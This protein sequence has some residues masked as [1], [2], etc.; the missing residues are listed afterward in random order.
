VTV[1]VHAIENAVEAMP[2]SGG[3]IR[4]RTARE[5]DHALISV[6]D[7]G[8][9]VSELGD[10]FEPL[11]STKGK[12][13]MGLGLSMIRSVA[14]AHGGSTSLVTREEGGAILEIKFPLTSGKAGSLE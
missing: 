10:V 1:L 8:P 11:V 9:G 4:V 14:N 5:N 7:S 6:Q 3:E 2:P 12:P 13:H